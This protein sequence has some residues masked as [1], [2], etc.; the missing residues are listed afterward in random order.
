M[1]TE[2]RRSR[3]IWNE[4]RKPNA[5][6]VALIK[7]ILYE[8]QPFRFSRIVD[9]FNNP[10]SQHKMSQW[11]DATYIFFQKSPNSLRRIGKTAAMFGK[12]RSVKEW[13]GLGVLYLYWK[14]IV[15]VHQV[16]DAGPVMLIITALVLIFT[17]GLRDNSEH[18]N[19]GM[20]AYSVFNRG[21][22]NMMGG[23]DVENLVAQHA[24]GGFMRMM[25]PRQPEREGGDVDRQNVRQH[26]ADEPNL[27]EV[28]VMAAEN[29]DG[30]DGPL[31]NRNVNRSR[32]SGKKARRDN[33]KKD[34]RREMQRQR[35]AAAAMGFGT[36]RGDGLAMN[37][38]LEEQ[39]ALA[40]Y[41]EP[42]FDDHE[43]DLPN[44][45]E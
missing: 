30:I 27:E 35:E 22:Q 6:K 19:G 34:L 20:S 33:K 23:V 28:A 1:F 3:A 8:I 2:G 45:A 15:W 44:H 32:K 39:V 26:V 38:L 5:P 13:A 21:F 41:E 29:E 18:E 37:R 40:N 31:P 9:F 42:D 7:A 25:V 24:G 10:D 12:E 43:N 14:F 16:M 17:I 36:D 4:T 11:L